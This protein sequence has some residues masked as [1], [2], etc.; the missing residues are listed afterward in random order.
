ML[1]EG[2]DVLNNTDNCLLLKSVE[3][4][5]VVIEIEIDI[6]STFVDLSE[7]LV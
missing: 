4:Y 1:G 5:L 6:Y 3:E 2:F 7:I